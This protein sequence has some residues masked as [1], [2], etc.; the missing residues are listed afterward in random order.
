MGPRWQLQEAK[1]KLGQVVARALEEGPQV[2]TLRGHDTVVLLSIDE[3]RSLIEPAQESLLDF[4]RRS[5]LYDTDIPPGRIQETRR[6]RA[7]Q[8]EL[9]E[10]FRDDELP[11]G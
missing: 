5:P 6:D 3:Y 10:M 11:G 9:A 8:H 4:M 1:N 2:I 7:R